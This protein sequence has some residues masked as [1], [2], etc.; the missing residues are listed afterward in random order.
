MSE[1]KV[2]PLPM[3]RTQAS[4]GSRWC[5]QIVCFPWVYRDCPGMRGR[6]TRDVP[7]HLESL[8]DLPSY[9]GRVTREHSKGSY[10]DPRAIPRGSCIAP[11]KNWHLEGRVGNRDGARRAFVQIILAGVSGSI[12]RLLSLGMPIFPTSCR[13]D[14]ISILF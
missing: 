8:Q 12:R 6:L 1:T 11:K 2:V 5:L 7:G 9:L 14:E 3:M 10:D 13:I 4:F